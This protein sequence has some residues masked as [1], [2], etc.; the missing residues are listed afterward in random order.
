[1]I[2][3]GGVQDALLAVCR[4]TMLL[5]G[6]GCLPPHLMCAGSVE[7]YVQQAGSARCWFTG[8]DG[9]GVQ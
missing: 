1:V 2:V 4:A 9:C 5:V 6:R 3:G 8:G 7:R